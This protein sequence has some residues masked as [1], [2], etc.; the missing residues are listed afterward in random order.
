MW[1]TGAMHRSR[2]GRDRLTTRGASIRDASPRYQLVADTLAKDIAKGRYPVGSTL[3]TEFELCELFSISRFTVREALRRLREA[4]L[5]TS[6]PRAGTT[7]IARHPAAP[8]TQSAES[9]DDLLQYAANTEMRIDQVHANDIDTATAAD[10]PIPS[11]ETWLFASGTRFREDDDLPIC[12]TRVYINPAFSDIAPKLKGHAGAIYRLIETRHN[13]FVAR[14]EQRI[15]AVALS[16]N[17][18]SRLKAD[19][20]DPAL[21]IVRLYFDNGGRLLEVS[22]SIHPATR[23]SYTMGLR[24]SE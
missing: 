8:Y 21:R 22:D 3:P 6:K 24:R 4:N 9:L 19:V 16:G 2:R 7:V 14:V 23:F 18:A 15:L 5:V 12:V 20:G 11:G 17:D 10:L 1:Q 13:V